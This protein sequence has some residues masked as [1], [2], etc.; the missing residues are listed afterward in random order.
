MLRLAV[1][2][3]GDCRSP[4]ALPTPPS[5]QVPFLGGTPGHSIQ[6][7]RRRASLWTWHLCSSPAIVSAVLLPLL[8]EPWSGRYQQSLCD[9]GD[10]EVLVQL[11]TRQI[12]PTAAGPADCVFR[13]TTPRLSD[14]PD[15][16]ISN[17]RGNWLYIRSVS[18][19]PSVTWG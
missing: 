7:H 5:A 11:S 6:P 10:G 19:S 2:A 12:L 1:C 13:C 17:E 15:K 8:L 3:D 16:D 18:V 9:G 4:S 14:V